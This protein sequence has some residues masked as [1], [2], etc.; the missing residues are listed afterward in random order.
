MPALRYPT[1][2]GADHK[3][4]LQK[5]TSTSFLWAQGQTARGGDPVRSCHPHDPPPPI[6]TPGSW[7]SQQFWGSGP[8][9]EI[10]HGSGQHAPGLGWPRRLSL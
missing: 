1:A 2:R 5:V 6:S 3:P 8:W 10:A 9:P 4:T 7:R